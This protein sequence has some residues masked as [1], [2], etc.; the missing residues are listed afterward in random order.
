MRLNNRRNDELR[1]IEIIRNYTKYADGSVLVC[2]GDTKVLCNASI[3]NRIPEFLNGKSMGWVTAEYSMLPMSTHVRCQR[4]NANQRSQ[5]ISRLISRSLRSCINLNILNNYRIIVDCDVIQADGG[6]RTAS[7]TGG[8]VAL[9]DAVSSLLKTNRIKVNPIKYFI[10]A[11][12]LGIKDNEIMLDLDYKEDSNCNSDINIVMQ[13]NNDLI[14]IQGT[15]ELQS[16]SLNELNHVVLTAQQ[17]ITYLI[18]YQKEVLQ[19]F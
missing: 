15:S 17:A 2:F 10:A 11:I 16:F 14:E 1:P 5:E 13:E 8:F 6:T 12:S 18:N 4:D 19:C 3:D 9:Y 7:I